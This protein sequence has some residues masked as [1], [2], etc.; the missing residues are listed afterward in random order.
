MFR[1]FVAGKAG[2]GFSFMEFNDIINQ[3]R[4]E[5]EFIQS[6]E[7]QTNGLYDRELV[8]I[9]RLLIDKYSDYLDKLSPKE[10]IYLFKQLSK[11]LA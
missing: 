10:A 3:I 4:Q 7:R 8:L 6:L 1:L 9:Y 11:M 5:P 2:W